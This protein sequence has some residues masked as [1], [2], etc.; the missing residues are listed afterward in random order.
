LLR[1]RHGSVICSSLQKNSAGRWTG[2][3]ETT[4]QIWLF[5]LSC[6]IAFFDGVRFAHVLTLLGLAIEPRTSLVV[7]VRVRV[8]PDLTITRSTGIG[9]SLRGLR[10]VSNRSRSGAGIFLVEET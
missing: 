10:L 6:V 9:R 8:D 2:A 1:F 4:K 3:E 5:V 7:D